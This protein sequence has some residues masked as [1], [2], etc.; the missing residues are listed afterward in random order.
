[1]HPADAL[2]ILSALEEHPVSLRLLEASQ[3]SGPV[4]RLQAHDCQALAAVAVRL[5]D[6][7]RDIAASAMGRAATALQVQVLQAE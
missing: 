2:Q 7:W 3:I 6:Q 1:M 5:V 4:A